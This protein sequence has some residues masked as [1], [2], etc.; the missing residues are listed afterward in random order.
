MSFSDW[1][2][3]VVSVVTLGLIGVV[4][5]QLIKKIESGDRVNANSILEVSRHHGRNDSKINDNRDHYIRLDTLVS[6]RNRIHENFVTEI[7]EF[8][9]EIRNDVKILTDR[10]SLERHIENGTHN[11]QR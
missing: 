4:W 6:E 3:A 7:R 8:M 2:W 1:V 9:K 11:G 5:N 10:R